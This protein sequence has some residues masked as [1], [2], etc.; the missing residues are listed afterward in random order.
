ML[1]LQ[2]CVESICMHYALIALG[3]AYVA[4]CGTPRRLCDFDLQ[5][6]TIARK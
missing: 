5:I 3:Y 6:Y 4:S 1:Q 2:Q